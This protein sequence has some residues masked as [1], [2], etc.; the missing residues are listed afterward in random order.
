MWNNNYIEYEDNDDR[1]KN[2][3]VKEYLDKIKPYLRDIITDPQKSGTWKVRLTI[4]IK[5]ISSTDVD[6][7]RV[8]HLK[9][10]NKKFMTYANVNDVIDELLESLLP[11]YQ[12]G[13]ETSVRGNDF[14]FDSV[15]LLYYKCHRI[16]FRGG[17]SY[18]DSPY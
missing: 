14:S 11:R 3:S 9:N 12:N 5:F 15:R 13:L 18:I 10:N 17:G 4:E 2:L 6:E 16:N 8:T 1:N 7:E